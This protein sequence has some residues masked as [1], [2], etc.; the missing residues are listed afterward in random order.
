MWTMFRGF[1][2]SYKLQVQNVLQDTPPSPTI[3]RSAAI[4]PGVSTMLL[5]EVLNL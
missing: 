4:C 1:T 5:Q 3:G 2:V